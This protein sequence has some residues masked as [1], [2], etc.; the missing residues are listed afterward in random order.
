MEYLSGTGSDAWSAA[1][2]AGG[3]SEPWTQVFGKIHVELGNE[4]VS[5]EAL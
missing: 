1:R 3:Q 5:G 2:I 4:S